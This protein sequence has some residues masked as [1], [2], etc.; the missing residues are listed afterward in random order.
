MGCESKRYDPDG[1][2]ALLGI[3]PLKRVYELIAVVDART[4]HYLRIEFDPAF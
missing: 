4:E 3:R 2:D 1:L